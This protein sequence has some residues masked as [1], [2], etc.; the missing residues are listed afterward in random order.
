MLVASLVILLGTVF[1]G[2]FFLGLFGAS[3]EVGYEL[4]VICMVGQVIRAISGMNQSLL[5]INGYQTRSALAAITGV[6]ILIT[7]AIIL[8]RNFGVIGIG[9]AVVIA[10]IAGALMLASQAQSLTGKRADLVWLLF[11][12]R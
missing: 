6:V 5:A 8:A 1:L 3:Y 12:S 2:R 11:Q 4:L 7:S 10:E 9:F